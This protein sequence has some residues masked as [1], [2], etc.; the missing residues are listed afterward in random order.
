MQ[1]ASDNWAGAEPRIVEAVAREAAKSG[2]AYGASAS[3]R[4][5]EQ[6]FSEIFERDV[7]VFI[8]GT[9]SAA[10]GLAMA[11]V[12]KPGG[13]VF[14]HRESHM[15]EDECGGVEY[16]T[17]GTRL[18]TLEGSTGKLDP[19]TLRTAIARF[20]PEFVHAGQPMAVSIAQQT[21][22]GG[23]YSLA[24]ISAIAAVAKERALPF[25][26][27]GS[28]C[29]NALV[30][31][32]V[33]PA[34]M[35]WRAGVDLLSFGATK[36]GCMSAEAVVFFEP[37]LAAEMPFL[38]KRA[39]HLFSKSRF[40]A[41]QFEAYFRDGLWLELAGRAIAMA[42]RLRA[43][44]ADTAHSRQ[45]WPTEGNEVFAVVKRSAAARLRQAGA[46]FYD[47]PEPHGAALGLAA[48]ECLVRLVTSFSTRPEEVDR[49]IAGLR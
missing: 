33:S 9:G 36:N 29:A 27:D 41:A 48:G 10:N 26:M 31:L 45:A 39:G 28:R 43:G 18:I 16:L 23:I 44:L 21:E 13:V 19:V 8:V 3:D 5:I 17:G 35:T 25:H 24:E 4:A 12:A 46:V 49:L 20:D 30:R 15:V 40:L 37:R 2:E 32:N 38:R 47:W 34:D 1:F 22:A 14:C 11:A 6:R 7:A 42:D